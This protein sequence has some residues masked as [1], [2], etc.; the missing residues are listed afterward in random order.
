MRATSLALLT[1]A[2]VLGLGLTAWAAD[3]DWGTGGDSYTTDSGFGWY[4]SAAQRSFFKTPTSFEPGAGGPEL[5]WTYVPTCDGNTPGGNSD[6]CQGALCT[7]PGGEPGVTFWVFSRPIDPPGADWD[8]VGTQCIPG[9]QR[10]DLADVEAQI[11][12]I[13]EDKFREIAEPRLQVAPEAGGLVNLPVLAWTDDP[14]ELTLD[15]EQPLPGSIRATPSYDWSWS[16]GTQSTGSGRPYTPALSPSATPDH[17]VHSVFT[18]RGD[19][20]VS[21][22]VT[23]Q[24]AVT[25]P[26]IAPIDIAPLVY[27]SAATF[28]VREARAQLV[29]AYG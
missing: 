1:G 10:V 21:L 12:G 9:E 29:D 22:T 16:N 5:Q 6:A 19:G 27:T 11:R 20:S 17:Y 26:G 3:R 24:G 23:W 4:Y 18:E 13:I 8:T 7:A 25:V 14:G 15:F 2:A 28:S